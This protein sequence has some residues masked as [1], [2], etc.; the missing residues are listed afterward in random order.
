MSACAKQPGRQTNLTRVQV[1][2]TTA[3]AKQP[4]RPTGVTRVQATG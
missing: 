1:T 4:G 3:C 2:R